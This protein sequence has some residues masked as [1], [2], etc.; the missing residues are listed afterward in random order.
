MDSLTLDHLNEYY[1]VQPELIP[2]RESILAIINNLLEQEHKF[3]RVDDVWIVPEASYSGRYFGTTILTKGGETV[4]RIAIGR[5][6][7][8]VADT[9]IHEAAHILL[10]KRHIRNINH[11]RKF[12]EMYAMLTNDYKDLVVAQLR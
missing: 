8:D 12:T 3:I 6:R 7:E 1:R 4:I 2:A 11:G 10:G 5:P 9:I